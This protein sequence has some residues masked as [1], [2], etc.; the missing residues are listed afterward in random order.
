MQ[1]EVGEMPA[2]WPEDRVEAGVWPDGDDHDGLGPELLEVEQGLGDDTRGREAPVG[3]I[4]TEPEQR[5]SIITPA[6][7]RIT[8]DERS[9]CHCCEEHHT[10]QKTRYLIHAPSRH[11]KSPQQFRP[12]VELLALAVTA[13]GETVNVEVT[14]FLVDSCTMRSQTSFATVQ[15]T[16]T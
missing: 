11:I 16:C 8:F 13:A 7:P 1:H 3:E 12:A 6:C 2:I 9:S 4:T 15:Y 14:I 10:C 5:K